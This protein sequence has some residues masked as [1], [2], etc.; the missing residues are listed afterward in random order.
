MSATAQQDA[1]L[2]YWFGTPPDRYRYDASRE[3]MWFYNGRQYDAEIRARFGDL[4]RAA[5]QGELNDWTRTPRGRLALIILLDQFSRHLQRGH[6][7]AFA[8][9][10]RAQT[11]CLDG[12][13]ESADQ[14]LHP[15]ERVFFYLPLE[16]AE[17]LE[18]Q[19]LSVR[20]YEQLWRELPAEQQPAYAGF[21]DY[22][23]RH[24][25]VIARFGRFPDLN[26][27]LGRDSTPEERAFL[28]RPGS[29]FL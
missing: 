13:A 29:S 10:D 12:L 9:D 25:L 5:V 21:L 20:L 26:E 27:L 7:Q 17:D 15:V 1:L 19:R 3:A 2:T 11:L 24:L 16:H 28:T 8:Q 14:T 22:A 6:A 23:E 4:Y 18:R